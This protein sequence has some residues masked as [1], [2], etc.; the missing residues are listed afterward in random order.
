MQIRLLVNLKERK[1][2]N[3]MIDDDKQKCLRYRRL[4]AND[5][6]LINENSGEIINAHGGARFVLL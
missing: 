6:R 2:S 5:R 4:I 1:A 3:F